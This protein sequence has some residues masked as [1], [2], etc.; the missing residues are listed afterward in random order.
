MIRGAVGQVAGVLRGIPM[1][2][3]A[4]S[5]ES[6]A[7][8]WRTAALWVGALGVQRPAALR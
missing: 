3:G 8:R 1:S 7:P 5:S 6:S 4:L 2:Q